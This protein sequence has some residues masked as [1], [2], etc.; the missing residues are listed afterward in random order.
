[1]AVS[2]SRSSTPIIQRSC[3]Y[4][5]LSEGCDTERVLPSTASDSDSKTS[6]ECN[7]ERKRQYQS[8]SPNYLHDEGDIKHFKVKIESSVNASWMHH[9]YRAVMIINEAAPGLSLHLNGPFPPSNCE[10]RT[11]TIKG[12]DEKDHCSTKD[13]VRHWDA[14]TI[15]LYHYWNRKPRTSIHELLHALGFHHEHQRKDAKIHIMYFG[16]EE[17]DKYFDDCTLDSQVF[18]LTPFDPFSI[19]LYQEGEALKLKRTND[20]VWKLKPT[21]EL[22]TDLSEQ[23]KLGLNLEYPP[24]H[25]SSYNPQKG[26]VTG[27]WYCGRH[28]MQNHNHPAN[29]TTDGC[30]GPTNWANC[31]ACRTLKNDVVT[32]FIREGCWQGWSG[33]VYCGRYFGKK[34]PGHDGYCGP[35]NGPPCLECAELLLPVDEYLQLK[36]AYCLKI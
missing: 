5:S 26:S 29:S 19:M 34:E 4:G 22:N 32:K 3:S 33:L 36:F 16:S 17:R 30:C 10:W 18:G 8:Q 23:D 27:M 9:I 24:C 15:T 11:I 13:D 21:K 35:N 6:E 20:P 12:T 1:M 28:V 7:K 14:A 2:S 25:S 31:P